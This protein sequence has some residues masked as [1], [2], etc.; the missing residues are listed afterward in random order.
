MTFYL[1]ERT[2]YQLAKFQ[3]GYL[4]NG[5]HVVV[6]DMNEPVRAHAMYRFIL[7]DEAPHNPGYSSK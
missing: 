6:K 3:M 1:S 4:I 5:T 7:R 2:V